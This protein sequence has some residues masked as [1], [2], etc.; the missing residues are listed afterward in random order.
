MQTISGEA[1]SPISRRGLDSGTGNDGAKLLLRAGLA[2]LMLFHGLSKVVG[3]IGFISWMLARAGLPAFLA[4][5]VY[6]GEVIAPLQMLIGPFTRPAALIIAA[7]MVVATVL[8]HSSELLTLS[9]TG[10]WALE[11]QGFFLLTA[12]VVAM[13]G[14]ERYSISRGVSKWN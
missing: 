6:A 10:G 3:G 2:L 4:D 13:Q 5:G 11:L 12:I 7:N 9:K 14:A 8:V 1:S